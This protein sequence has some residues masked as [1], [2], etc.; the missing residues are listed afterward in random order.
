M[1]LAEP[2]ALPLLS[3]AS[4][5]HPHPS[6]SRFRLEMGGTFPTASVGTPYQGGT[7]SVRNASASQP[8]EGKA[9]WTTP[10]TQRLSDGPSRAAAWE[11][12]NNVRAWVAADWEVRAARCGS[13][14]RQDTE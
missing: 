8:L 1:S 13:M 11:M 5:T 2:P 12:M 10:G 3:P 14:G 6:A 4:Q 7:S 9:S